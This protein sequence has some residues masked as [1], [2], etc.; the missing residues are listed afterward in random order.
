[1]CEYYSTIK[2]KEILPLVTT[3]M[4]LKGIMLS[5]ITDRERQI[6]YILT[7]KWNLKKQ[8]KKPTP[9]S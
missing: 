9:S 5:E 7:Y 2:N 1:M 3:W 6:P 8:N 4:E